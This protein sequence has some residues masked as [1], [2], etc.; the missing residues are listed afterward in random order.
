MQHS[1]YYEKKKT[2]KTKNSD[3]REMY[4][5]L[6]ITDTIVNLCQDLVEQ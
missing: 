6:Q 1:G 3:S 2:F 4:I 5:H